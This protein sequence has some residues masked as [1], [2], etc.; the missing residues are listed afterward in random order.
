MRNSDGGPE[1]RYWLF[2][3]YTKAVVGVI[4]AMG[5]Y[6]AATSPAPSWEIVL[7]LAVVAGLMF[8]APSVTRLVEQIIA[9]LPWT[10]GPPKKEDQKDGD[11]D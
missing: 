10:P 11:A 9:A 5:A 6:V 8:D 1:Q 7:G 3:R 2:V 4:C